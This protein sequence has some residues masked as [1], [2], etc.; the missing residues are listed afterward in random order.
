MRV[1]FGFQLLTE[2]LWHFLQLEGR[3]FLTTPWNSTK[4]KGA[5]NFSAEVSGTELSADVC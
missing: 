3:W 2:R 1:M 5:T 4:R